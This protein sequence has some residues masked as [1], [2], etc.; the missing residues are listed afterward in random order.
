MIKKVTIK[1]VGLRD[2]KVVNGEEVKFVFGKGKD[3]GKEFVMVSIQTDQT[4]DEY[5][6]TPSLPTDRA[7]KLQVGDNVILRFT[8]SKSADGS[9]VFKNFNFVSKK[10][11]EVYEAAVQEA[12]GNI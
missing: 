4:G 12:L 7:A 1:S 11:E 5:F 3:A 9:K 8:E 6:G 2:H 10:E